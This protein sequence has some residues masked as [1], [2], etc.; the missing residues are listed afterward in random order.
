MFEHTYRQMNETIV[1]EERLKNEVLSH[2][3]PSRRRGRP[4]LLAAVLALCLFIATPVLA[5]NIPAVYEFMYLV[6]PSMAQRFQPVQERCERDGI[7]MEVVSTSVHDNIIEVYVT[8]Q[9]LTGDRVDETT[10]LFDSYSVHRAYDCT[11]HCE[12]VGYD[13]ETKTATFL[14]TL[15]EWDNEKILDSKLTFSVGCFLS[16]KTALEDTAVPLD[17]T[18]AGEE[19]SAAPETLGSIVGHGGLKNGTLPY[20]LTPGEVLYTPVDHLYITG[21][22]YVDGR[23]H[24]QLMTD[25]KLSLDPH[26]YVYLVTREGEK[27]MAAESVG[28]MTEEGGR[29]L[30]YEE[31]V[32]DATPEQVKEYSLYGSFW[33]SGCCTEGPWQV[34][35]PLKGQ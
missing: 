8:L 26:G 23:L 17:L 9:D 1:P 2:G 24:L 32:F 14:I 21:A 18:A 7:C 34:T 35:F 10:D 12:R 15:E 19:E 30:D 3:M 5:A 29:R 25:E 6:S 11:A 33:T 20:V 27:L 13:A 16:R 22:G 4:L 28:F 31:F